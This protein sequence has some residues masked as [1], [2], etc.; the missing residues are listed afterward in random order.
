MTTT[1]T[2]TKTE[3]YLYP[4]DDDRNDLYLPEGHVGYQAEIGD[5]VYVRET[6]W[7]VLR[8]VARDWLHGSVNPIVHKVVKIIRAHDV[9]LPDG[10][11][12]WGT[13]YVCQ[14]TTVSFELTVTV[15]AVRLAKAKVQVADA[16]PIEDDVFPVGDP[17]N[18]WQLPERHA[19]Y[20]AEVGD[21]VWIREMRCGLRCALLVHDVDGRATRSVYEVVELVPAETIDVP[22]GVLHMPTH[23]VCHNIKDGSIE[24]VPARQLV[25]VKAPTAAEPAK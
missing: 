2:I 8:G 22:G 16:T 5:L 3:D 17:R 18:E 4:F 25:K 23:Y 19:G 21:Q 20:E 10:T 9:E 15:P 13:Q 6:R 11:G 7:G 12:H 24:R 14:D 1:V